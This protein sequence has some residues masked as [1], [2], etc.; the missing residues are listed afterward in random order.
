M[1]AVV[2]LCLLVLA[3]EA[4]PK[5]P[6]KAN[7]C[8]KACTDD[9]TPVCGYDKEPKDGKSFGNKCVLESYVCEHGGKKFAG[10]ANG[11]CPGSKGVRLS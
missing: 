1:K 6:P 8:A 9:Y 2:I 5:A 4:A 11:E 7:Q 3:I 10:M